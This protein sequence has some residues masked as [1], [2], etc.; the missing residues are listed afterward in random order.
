MLVWEWNGFLQKWFA[1]N[2][3]GYTVYKVKNKHIADTPKGRSKWKTL[4][5]AQSMCESVYK[6]EI[7][8]KEIQHAA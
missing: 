6:A 2:V 5:E 1:S 4:D 3:G 7:L 8:V